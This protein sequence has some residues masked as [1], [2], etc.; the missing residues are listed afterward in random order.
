MN[1][2]LLIEKPVF[3]SPLLKA[4]DLDKAMHEYMTKRH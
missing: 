1:L 3:D 2:P 4:S